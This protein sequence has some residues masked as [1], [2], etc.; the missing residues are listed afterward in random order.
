MYNPLTKK[1]GKAV[2][3]NEDKKTLVKVNIA[4][5]ESIFL[6]TG[7]N[8][9]IQAWNY[10]KP[11]ESPI[12]ITGNWKLSFLKGGPKLP[13]EQILD[14]LNSWTFLGF[15]AENFSGT[16]KYE[17]EFNKPSVNADNWKL[18]LGDV[19]ESAKI[20]L[21]DE[22]VGTVWSNPFKL[23]IGKLKE[24]KNKLV[25]Q[26]TNLSANRIR[27]KEIRGE[28]WKI[29]HEINMVNKDYQK[30]DATL[31]KPMPSGLLGPITITPLKK[32]N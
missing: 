16:A 3:K 18:A 30:F 28:E 4:S 31:W 29:F 23:N 15:D 26:V 14:S 5:G 27:A 9:N 1:Y 32:S 13:K 7:K 25:M 8:T 10:Y 19:R 6:K 17:I 21:N 12:N 22:F 2:I 24:G 11:I 20:W